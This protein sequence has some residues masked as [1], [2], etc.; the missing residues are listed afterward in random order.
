ML[1][2]V[3]VLNDISQNDLN[4]EKIDAKAMIKKLTDS[5]AFIGSANVNMIRTRKQLMKRDLP[6][7][8]QPLCSEGLGF[9]AD[10]LFGENLSLQLKEISELN[11]V[12][13]GFRQSSFRYPMRGSRGNLRGF[14]GGRGFRRHRFSPYNRQSSQRTAAR[15]SG[16]RKSPSN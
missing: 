5:I 1:P 8:M 15:Y 6:S 10:F 3:E 9:S 16:N 14:R 2:L 7:K 11:R 13:S 4:L 12:T